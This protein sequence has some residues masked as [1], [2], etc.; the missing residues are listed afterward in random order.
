MSLAPLLVSAAE[1]GATSGP[2]HWVI[3]AG[4]LLIFV[5]MLAGLLAFGGGRD[6]T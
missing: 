3:G 5:A 4:V 1:G 2:N 6:H